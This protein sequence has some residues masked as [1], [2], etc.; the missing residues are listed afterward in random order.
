MS[1][2]FPLADDLRRYQAHDVCGVERRKVSNIDSEN[3]EVLFHKTV[4]RVSQN[5]V[6]VNE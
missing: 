5:R 4:T 3:A 2:P 1:P 6:I